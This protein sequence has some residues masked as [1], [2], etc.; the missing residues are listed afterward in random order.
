MPMALLAE[1]TEGTLLVCQDVLFGAIAA[2][3][4]IVTYLGLPPSH[5]A[6]AIL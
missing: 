1:L 6:M 4:H 5:V 3:P 2:A